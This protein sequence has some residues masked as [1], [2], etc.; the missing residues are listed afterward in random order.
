MWV[1]EIR[2]LEIIIELDRFI[3]L[4]N[5]NELWVGGSADNSSYITIEYFPED[6]N[7]VQTTKFC[8]LSIHWNNKGT[9]GCGKSN[10]YVYCNGKK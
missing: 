1:F 4:Y 10:S 7:P 5:N 6:A 2:C 9:S 3:A 8:A